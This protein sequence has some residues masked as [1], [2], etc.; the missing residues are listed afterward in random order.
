MEIRRVSN[1]EEFR[2]L[3]ALLVAYEYDLPESLR[4]GAVPELADLKAAYGGSDT[5]LLAFDEVGAAGCVAVKALDSQT[6]ILARLFVI[7]RARG[8]G[9]ARSL[10]SA[11]IA[12]ARESFARIVLDTDKEQLPAAYRLYLSLGFC[13]CAPYAPVA[14]ASPTF[15]ELRLEKR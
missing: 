3:H 6:A 4:H 7:P 15:M 10:A 8:R 5:A 11:A 12:L 13:E 9:A 2:A 1:E 14:Y